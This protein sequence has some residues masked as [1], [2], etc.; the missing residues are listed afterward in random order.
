MLAF[1]V[2]LTFKQYGISN[3]EEVQHVYGR[4]LLQFY[5]SGFTDESAFHYRNL[6]LYGG[7][8]D[9]IAA[10][11][12][13]LMHMK[14]ATAQVWDMRHLLSAAFGFVGI[15]ASYKTARIVGGERAGLLVIVLLG[16]TGAWS[17]A[18]FT[19]TKDIPFAACMAW[20][21]YYLIL[22]APELP[23][24]CPRLVI[25][26]GVALG[27]ALGLR[28]GAAFAAP[29]LLLLLLYTT[30]TRSQ[31]LRQQSW[32]LLQSLVSLLPAALVALL[33]MALFWPWGVM[34]PAHPLQAIQ[35]FSYF[36]FDMQTI[37]DG[38]VM[39]IGDVPRYYLLA[40]LLVRLPEIFL[41][42]LFTALVCATYRLRSGPPYSHA[43]VCAWLV[44]LLAALFPLAFVLWD[45][46]ALYNGIRHFTFI[47]PPLAIIAAWGLGAAWEELA[48]HPRLR[49]LA[50]LAAISLALG[51]LITLIQ[52]HPY[53]YVYYNH[54]AGS[55][56]RAEK[57]WEGDYWSSSLREAAGQLNQYVNKNEPAHKKQNH[58]PYLVAVC[59]ENLQ[60]EV[61][62]DKRFL[63]TS[64]WPAADFFLSSTNMSCD[65]ALDGKI[66][67]R[68]ERMGTVLAVI[69]DRRNLLVQQRVQAAAT[70][71]K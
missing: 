32:F 64:N 53:Q 7:F 65:Q 68:V 30:A 59:A 29:Y 19:H 55:I 15:L 16:L 62:L 50:V 61:F 60:A 54:L 26:L 38:Q 41:L 9:L 3:D 71:S 13:R 10:S 63:V 23:H 36:S 5:T 39:K 40:Y 2:L 11:V 27:C 34:S 25:G 56:E 58:S 33:L 21:T 69:K 67:D 31:G 6:Y 66:I 14:M 49:V 43:R 42:G 35:A 47:L 48:Q 22:L 45:K 70:L 4:L 24:P 18:M 17:G 37:L 28:V 57:Q 51:T 44:L 46:P 8:F 12:E 20:V 1:F 52:L